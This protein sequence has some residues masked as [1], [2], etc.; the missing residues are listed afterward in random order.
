MQTGRPTG[1]GCRVWLGHP[2]I[3]LSMLTGVFLCFL[4][5]LEN[6]IGPSASD[7]PY[8]PGTSPCKP[9]QPKKLP[10]AH[11]VTLRVHLCYAQRSELS[12]AGPK[13]VNRAA[14]LKRLPGVGCSNLLGHVVMDSLMCLD[15]LFDTCPVRDL[16][17]NRPHVKQ[18]SE[19][20]DVA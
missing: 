11:F 10:P 4:Y 16:M 20:S 13:D 17:M 6:F 5:S 1:V 3:S 12:H 15:H 14:E 19:T 7:K 2:T 9:A 8:V 18:N